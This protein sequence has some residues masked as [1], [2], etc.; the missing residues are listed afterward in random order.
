MS[1]K[2]YD[3]I[4]QIGEIFEHS[5]QFMV[6]FVKFNHMYK[7]FVWPELEDSDI[8]TK[9]AVVKVLPAP[10]I[11]RRGNTFTFPIDFGNVKFL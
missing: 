4:G 9:E 11:S 10:I 8:V 7:Y 6:K 3:F 2:S 5:G 1:E